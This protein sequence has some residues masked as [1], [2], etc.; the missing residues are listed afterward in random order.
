MFIVFIVCFFSR[1]KLLIF[2]CIV[3]EWSGVFI[4]WFVVTVLLNVDICCFWNINPDKQIG[5]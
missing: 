5:N 1:P 3:G 2:F 4:C